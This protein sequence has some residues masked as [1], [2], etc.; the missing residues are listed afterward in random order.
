[1]KIFITGILSI[2]ISLVL[3]IIGHIYT[4]PY[5]ISLGDWKTPIGR[6]VSAL[7]ATGNIVPIKISIISL[8]FGICLISFS[9]LSKKNKLFHNDYIKKEN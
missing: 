2:L 1:M 6:Y 5:Y 9:L 3:F 8:I 7:N 4:V